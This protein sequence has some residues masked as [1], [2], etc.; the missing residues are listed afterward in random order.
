M[1]KK[2]IARPI[3]DIR[4]EN[5]LTISETK[6]E[7]GGG[8]E[9]RVGRWIVNGKQGNIQIERREYWDSEGNKSYRKAKGLTFDDAK[10]IA[11]NWTDLEFIMQGRKP[12]IDELIETNASSKSNDF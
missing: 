1:I 11:D 10:Y 2:N 3:T 12:L 8:S 9:F 5:M 6:F 4:W 7:K